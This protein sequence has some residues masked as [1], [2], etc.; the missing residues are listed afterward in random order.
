MPSHC[1]V[2]PQVNISAI[3]ASTQTL[4]LVTQYYYCH[5]PQFMN[6]QLIMPRESVAVLERDINPAIGDLT[7]TK[8]DGS[9]T[10]PLKEFLAG[11]ARKQAMMMAHKV[12]VVFEEFPGMNPNDLSTSGCPPERRRCHWSSPSLWQRA[13]STW[14]PCAAGMS[15]NS[16]ARLGIDAPVWTAATMCVGLDIEETFK[17]VLMPGS[18]INNFHSTF[19]GLYDVPYMKQLQT[20]QSSQR[21]ATG[22]PRH[23]AVFLGRH[24]CFNS[25][26]NKWRTNLSASFSRRGSGRR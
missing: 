3:P 13:K 4:V 7:F 23:D 18:W 26:A 16:R 2:N 5:M 22:R 9:Q 12:K 17:S 14:T 20:A 15:R 25:F 24:P 11:P 6:Q 10:V 21:R 19:L 1:R 8:E